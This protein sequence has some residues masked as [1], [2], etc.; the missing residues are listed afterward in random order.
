MFDCVPGLQTWSPIRGGKAL[1][2]FLSAPGWL[3]YCWCVWPSL[4]CSGSLSASSWG[5]GGSSD[6]NRLSERRPHQ[7]KP[8]GRLRKTCVSGSM[9]QLLFHFEKHHWH[10]VYPVKLVTMK[11]EFLKQRMEP[12]HGP[13]SSNP[14][15]AATG[16]N[17]GVSL[18]WSSAAAQWNAVS[19][20]ASH[21]V[22]PEMFQGLCISWLRLE[23][24]KTKS[25]EITWAQ[26]TLIPPHISIF[27][28][29][30]TQPAIRRIIIAYR[31]FWI[32]RGKNITVK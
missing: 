2:F 7:N 15:K 29:T 17:S 13:K 30:H 18:G 9:Q 25:K 8:F 19:H 28:Y 1:I 4:G 6:T 21:R 27:L 16:P 32:E 12:P 31:I 11:M 20:W 14:H 22:C 23:C 3:F 10:P 26:K 24:W 5:A